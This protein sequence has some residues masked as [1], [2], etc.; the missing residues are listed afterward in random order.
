MLLGGGAGTDTLSG[1]ASND[2]LIG[3]TGNDALTTGNGADIIV[4]NKGDGKDT[5][6]ASSSGDN[7][8]SLG[9]GANYADLL[10]PE[11]R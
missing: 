3:G 1:G 4:F 9:G 10:F 7:T 11:E 6:A 5:V 2:L 8:L